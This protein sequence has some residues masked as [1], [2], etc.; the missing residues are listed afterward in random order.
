MKFSNNK[1]GSSAVLTA[2]IFTAFA[3][4]AVAAVEICRE[5]AVK[6]E[7]EAFG[8]VWT[9]AI[10][11]EYDLPLLEDYG[12]MAYFGNDSEVSEKVDYYLDYSA[13]GRLGIDIG[14]ANADLAGYE[15]GDPDNFLDAVKK[16][17]TSKVI[18]DIATGTERRERSIKEGTD[19]IGSE[20][21]GST[22]GKGRV[23]KNKVVLGTLPSAGTGSGYSVDGLVEKAKS[24]GSAGGVKSAAENAGA[25]VLFIIKH[26]DNAVT[27]AGDKD[28]FFRNEWEYIIMGSPDDADNLSKAKRNIF[29]MRNALNLFSLYKDPQKVEL[30][31]EIAETITPGPLGMVTQVLVAEAWAAL[32]TESDMKELLDNKRVPVL[33]DASEWKTGLGAVLDS[34]RVRK[35][36]DDESKELLDE[37]REDIGALEG[38]K[39]RIVELKDGLSYDDHLMI[40]ILAM[41]ERVRLLRTMDLVQINMKYRYYRDFN[42]MEYYVGTRFGIEANGR[43]YEF[44]ESYK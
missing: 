16:G 11:S 40:M 19:D 30:I 22:S 38:I 35:K 8:R 2:M 42:M 5:M 4:C 13:A 21:G 25:E 31:L 32:E 17:L 44:E 15:L 6:S 33:K 28:S 43:N 20:E 26:F 34:D 10:L 23:I 37:N 7:C 36:L 27:Y 24:L 14:G 3:V 1:R 29:L 12:I 41:D 18:G 39:D 9:K